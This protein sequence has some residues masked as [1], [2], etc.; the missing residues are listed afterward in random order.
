MQMNNLAQADAAIR[1]RLQEVGTSTRGEFAELAPSY[2]I[3]Y[4]DAFLGFMHCKGVIQLQL[5]GAPYGRDTRFVY[6]R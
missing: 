3:A 4:I 6:E 1:Q 5:D 2:P